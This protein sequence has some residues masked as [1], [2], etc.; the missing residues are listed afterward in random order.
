MEGH[1]PMDPRNSRSIA[2]QGG[3]GGVMGVPEF[4][5]LMGHT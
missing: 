1:C 3:G 4:E 5:P 2:P